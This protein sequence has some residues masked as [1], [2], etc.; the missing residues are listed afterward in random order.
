MRWR[1]VCA[2]LLILAT[3][4][5]EV[6]AQRPRLRRGTRLVVEATAYCQRGETSSGDRTSRGLVAADT[7]MLPIGTVFR[8]VG[9]SSEYGG[10]YWV[11]DRGPEI[12]GREI[13]I[14]MP[15]CREAKR[16]G[17]RRLE[18]RILKAG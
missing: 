12:R 7:R 16:F 11:A 13:D 3:S 18:L 6:F 1:N 5:A 17:R 10:V 15:N 8:I 4:Q 2:C 9:P 14:F